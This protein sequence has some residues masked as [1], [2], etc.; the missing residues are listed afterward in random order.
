[1][2]ITYDAVNKIITVT[3]YTEASPCTF[4]DVYLADVA[5]GWGVVSKQGDKQY[6]L[7]CRL[8]I[9]DG[10]TATWFATVK[11]QITF[12][13]QGASFNIIQTKANSNF[14]SGVLISSAKGQGKDGSAFLF[15]IN[16]S[17]HTNNWIRFEAGSVKLYASKFEVWNKAGVPAS[18]SVWLDQTAVVEGFQ[19]LCSYIRSYRGGTSG[20]VCNLIVVGSNSG[21]ENC[22]FGTESEYLWAFG[23]AMDVLTPPNEALGRPPLTKAYFETIRT[24]STGANYVGGI[25]DF[26]G[27]LPFPVCVWDG[28][29]VLGCYIK[30]YATVKVKV[31][32]KNNNSI[33]NATVQVK[34]KDGVTQFETSTDTNGEAT[35]TVWCVKDAWSGSGSGN[36]RTDYNDFTLKITKAGY[37]DFETKL[38]IYKEKD[39]M[40]TLDGLT[41]SYDNIMK[42]LK[43]LEATQYAH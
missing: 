37:A 29:P 4:E 41:Y 10:S 24:W 13:T 14:R 35:G 22:Y 30:W 6:S 39:L 40:I 19:I 7:N 8:V 28:T 12:Y 20:K 15:I 3:G 21:F 25:K 33:A 23:S 1:M 9:G 17:N 27:P 11:E 34:N 26:L 32:D 31:I 18:S 43:F 36:T 38:T 5:G 2:P 16:N 42:K